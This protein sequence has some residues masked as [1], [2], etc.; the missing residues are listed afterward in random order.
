MILTIT[1]PTASGKT[2]I[3][4]EA[5]L[6]LGAEIISTDS[7]QFYRFMDIGTAKPSLS[8]RSKVK[9]HFIDCVDP[10]Q[11]L[12]A[13]SFSRMATKVILEL[14]DA[15]IPVIITGGSGLYLMG[16]THKF[17]SP[18]APDSK[19][20]RR[21]RQKLETLN[22]E[23]VRRHLLGR[24]PEV[25]LKI[26]EA[27]T[28]RI[29]RLMELDES[30]DDNGMPG[31]D[32]LPLRFDICEIV[33]L[34][35]REELFERIC[36]R[37]DLMISSGLRDETLDLVQRGFAQMRVV[38]ETIG[39]REILQHLAGDFSL[40]EAASLIKLHT[41]Q[42]AKRQLTWLRKYGGSELNLPVAES[43]AVS[44]ERIIELYNKE[45]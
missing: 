23:K 38:R 7:R 10:D 5:A 21:I 13:G 42:Y 34:R 44:A 6:K 32:S 2:D 4:V 16:L 43:P 25:V 19:K 1:G 36:E 28:R 40:E 18:S 17:T 8:V 11:P 12:T 31:L 26:H 20:R 35:K 33:L 39:Y 22:P 14:T 30:D 41:R 27:D 24:Y 15:D 29:S 45:K 3:A 9:H 37:V